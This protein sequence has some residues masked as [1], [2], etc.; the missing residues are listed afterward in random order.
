MNIQTDKNSDKTAKAKI[1]IIS[2]SALFFVLA[3]FTPALLII[4]YCFEHKLHQSV[5]IYTAPVYGQRPTKIVVNLKDA[6]RKNT[7]E[8]SGENIRNH[9]SLGEKDKRK[10]SYD[11]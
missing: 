6:R 2:R 5:F 3:S 9:M 10:G 1:T 7:L 4:V 11:P 8:A